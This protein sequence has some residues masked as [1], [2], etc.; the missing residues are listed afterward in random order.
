MKLWDLISELNADNP[1]FGLFCLL[2]LIIIV[3]FSLALAE[4]FLNAM[5]GM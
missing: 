2:V 1:D 4:L 3:C 5:K